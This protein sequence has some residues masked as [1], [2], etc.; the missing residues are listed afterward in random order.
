LECSSPED[1]VSRAVEYG[2]NREKLAAL[3]AKLAVGRDACVLFDTPKLV[4]HLED[5]YRQMWS[6][7]RNGALPEPDLR[8]LDVYHDIGV[9][10]ELENMDTLSDD[11]YLIWRSTA[12]SWRNGMRPIR[13]ARTAGSGCRRRRRPPRGSAE[14][15]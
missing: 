5:L 6:D 12:K 14:G 13:S 3:K 8:N 11:A 9:E 4:R 2:Q 10:F 15:P 1:Y 7:F